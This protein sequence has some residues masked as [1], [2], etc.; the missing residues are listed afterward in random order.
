[1]C[2]DKTNSLI[3]TEIISRHRSVYIQIL[4]IYFL[5][6]NFLIKIIIRHFSQVDGFL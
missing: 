4:L 6:F 5:Y 2:I 1:M 3:N